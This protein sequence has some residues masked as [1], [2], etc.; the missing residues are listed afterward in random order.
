MTSR[1]YSFSEN[2]KQL[3]TLWLSRV[4]QS[5]YGLDDLVIEVRSLA[6]GKGLFL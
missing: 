4:A 1:N 3:P 6:E 5:G 2:V